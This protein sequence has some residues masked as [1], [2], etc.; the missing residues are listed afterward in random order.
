MLEKIQIWASR[1]LP[2]EICGLV[3]GGISMKIASLIHPSALLVGFIFT[4]GENLGYYGFI[5]FRELYRKKSITTCLSNITFEFGIP[6]ILDSLIVRPFLIAILPIFF[7]L[8]IA[9][10]IFYILTIFFYEHRKYA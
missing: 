4:F 5:F 3:F 7:A 9:N 2:A 8:I 6:E 1:Y 10:L